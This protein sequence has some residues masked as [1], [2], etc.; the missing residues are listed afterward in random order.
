MHASADSESEKCSLSCQLLTGPAAAR[1]CRFLAR[2]EQLEAQ[3]R[4]L[5]EQQ[6]Q[7]QAV[8]ASGVTTTEVLSSLLRMLQVKAE[9]YRSGAAGGAGSLA[10]GLGDVG[11]AKSFSTGTANV[12]VL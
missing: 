6:R 1:C 12:M 2:L 3:A 11:A 8:E 4:Q 9:W 7:L 5:R 10:G